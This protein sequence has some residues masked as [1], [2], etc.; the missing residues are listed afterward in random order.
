MRGEGR[1]LSAWQGAAWPL[2][3][4]N[5]SIRTS[6]C[7]LLNLFPPPSIHFLTHSA[8]ERKPCT[9]ACSERRDRICLPTGSRSTDPYGPPPPLTHSA[10]ER[11]PCSLACSDRRARIRLAMPRL[12]REASISPR[13]VHAR[14]ACI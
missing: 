6:D 7:P 9:L 11:K 1:V 4:M 12:S 3:R 14:H 8:S 13:R 10:K 2:I 5:S